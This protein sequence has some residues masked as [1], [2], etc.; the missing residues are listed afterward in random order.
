MAGDLAF[1]YP[2]RLSVV[3]ASLSLRSITTD[4]WVH[5][6]IGGIDTQHRILILPRK[7]NQQALYNFDI[8]ISIKCITSLFITQDPKGELTLND[9]V[10]LQS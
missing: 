5:F 7:H 1:V 10:F 4:G 6:W 3:K 8:F 2:R 9:T